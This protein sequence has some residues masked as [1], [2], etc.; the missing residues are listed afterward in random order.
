MKCL[1]KNV[2][3]G[4]AAIALV[5]LVLKPSW[6]LTALPLLLLAACP[7]SMMFMMRRRPGDAG[8]CNTGE[9]AGAPPKEQ[10]ELN[11][12]IRALQSELRA[13]K[14]DQ[15]PRSTPEATTTDS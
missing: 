5:V 3:I 13:L 7:L 15:A 8:S 6:L 1:N 10:A 2:L 12:E 4:L 9:T 11:R 14:A